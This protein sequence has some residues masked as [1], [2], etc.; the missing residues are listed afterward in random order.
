MAMPTLGITALYAGL[1]ALLLIYTSV[2]V[3]LARVKHKINAGDG[4]NAD[5]LSVIRTQGNLIEY[6]PM[7]IILMALLEVGGT[8][9]WLLHTLGIVFVV[10]RL[11]HAS[12]NVTAKPGAARGIGATLSWVMIVAGGVLAIGMWQGMMVK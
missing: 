5:L 7:A 1:T 3:T 6:A 8:A 9:H 4:G 2:K 10:G 11:I 12:V